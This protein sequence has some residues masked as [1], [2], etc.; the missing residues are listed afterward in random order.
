[1]PVSTLSTRN[2]FPGR[3][4]N[5]RLR[6]GAGFLSPEVTRR[7][8]T[9]LDRYYNMSGH[10]SGSK[11]RGQFCRSSR[12]SQLSA[13][14][15]NYGSLG[16]SITHDIYKN[17]DPP[18][19]PAR[20]N[21]FSDSINSPY[22]NA[23]NRKSAVGLMREPGGFRRDYIVSKAQQQGKAPPAVATRSF[24]DYM[25]LFNHFAGE[26]LESED[27]YDEDEEE[28][29]EAI[30]SSGSRRPLLGRSGSRVSRSAS[31]IEGTASLSKTFFL[32]FKAFVGTGVLFLPKAFANGGIVFASIVSLFVAFLSGLSMLLLVKVREAIPGGFGEIGGQLFG[33]RMKYMILF[34]IAISQIGF[35]CAYMIFIAKNLSDL[36]QAISK[37]QMSVSDEAL[38]MVQLVLY[39][40]FSWLRKMHSLSS[41]ALLANSAIFFGLIYIYVS[42]ISILVRDGPAP[43]IAFNSESFGLFLGTAF[44]TFEG[45]GLVIPIVSSMKEPE[46]FPQL[47]TGAML[48]ISAIFISVGSLSYAAFGENVQAV[49]LLNLPDNAVTQT[50]QSLY[51]IAI[52]LTVPL[53]LFPAIRIIENALFGKKTG[54]YSTRVKVEKN[55]FRTVLC[56]FT[57]FVSLGGYSN[58]DNF[59][60]LIGALACIPLAFIFPAMFHLKAL[61]NKPWVKIGDVLL[62]VFGTCVMIFVTINTISTWGTH[63]AKDR[64]S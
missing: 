4:T 64:C 12:D 28:S 50:A 60:A 52:A 9:I 14:D 19:R 29:P 42:D 39:I 31:Q 18:Q 10:K 22:V 17:I 24:M 6:V 35:S 61:A 2:Q 53:M 8:T 51:V 16:A 49:I 34:S 3:G 25:Y 46:K 54:K 20:S 15:F 32:L 26:D 58:L 45:I 33:Q 5:G 63:P 38:I 62:L 47:L 55:I 23:E 21:S 56:I 37:C 57:A 48:L 11:K 59:V 1:M 43:L 40:P 36:I 13:D 44:F 27:E 30:E 41:A 7:N